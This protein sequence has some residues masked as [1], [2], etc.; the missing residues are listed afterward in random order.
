M[1][2]VKEQF[3]EIF[4]NLPSYISIGEKVYVK[5]LSIDLEFSSG[6]ERDLDPTFWVNYHEFNGEFYIKD[7]VLLRKHYLLSS[8]EH[9]FTEWYRFTFEEMLQD[10]REELLKWDYKVLEN[11][12]TKEDLHKELEELLNKWNPNQEENL[13]LV[14]SVINSLEIFKPKAEPE[15]DT[16]V[17]QVINLMN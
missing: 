13:S 7:S 12:G 15:D 5:V 14:D 10:S 9:P 16:E 6:Q 1:K 11:V 2:N 17:E 8:S 4:S 3:E